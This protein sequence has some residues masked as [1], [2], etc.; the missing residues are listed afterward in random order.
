MDDKYPTLNGRGYPDTVTPAAISTDAGFGNLPSQPLNSKIT[1]TA[2]QR[3]LLRLSN[4]AVTR[5]YTL[6]STIPMNVVGQ[7]A[8]CCAGR[9][10][11]NLSYKTNSVTLGG[12]ESYDVIL[13]TAGVAPGTYLLYTT[14]LNYLSNDAEDFGGM[15]TEITIQL[16]PGAI[17]MSCNNSAMRAS[18]SRSWPSS[19]CA[20]RARLRPRWSASPARRS[21]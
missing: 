11:A 18:G 7:S 4:L 16:G 17:T 6:A 2:G 15:M 20:P 14:N 21:R 10:A 12:G 3:V 9:A 13:D 8:G 1:A 5:F 19:A